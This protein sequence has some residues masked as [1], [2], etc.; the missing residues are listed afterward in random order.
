[1]NLVK[2]LFK[3]A[4]TLD[5]NG[6]YEEANILTDVM[7][8]IA[9]YTGPGSTPEFVATNYSEFMKK[10]PALIKEVER[11]KTQKPIDGAIDISNIYTSNPYWNMPTMIMEKDISKRIQ[12]IQNPSYQKVLAQLRLKFLTNK[13]ENDDTL[14][15]N[16]R[17]RLTNDLMYL[18][19]FI[20]VGSL[21]ENPAMNPARKTPETAYEAMQQKA[22]DTLK[23]IQPNE[24]NYN[25]MVYNIILKNL[26]K[27]MPGKSREEISLMLSDKTKL[28][29]YKFINSNPKVFNDILKDIRDLSNKFMDKEVAY[30]R[31]SDIFTSKVMFSTVK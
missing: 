24:V 5:M 26:I 27:N 18:K 10:H 20:G 15:P 31:L 14:N 30:K 7:H 13:L 1:M 2:S 23:S 28:Q 3:I 8:K 21:S 4:N 17:A 22:D 11:L 16:D 19:R 6:R 9:Q 12:E 25:Q 29:A